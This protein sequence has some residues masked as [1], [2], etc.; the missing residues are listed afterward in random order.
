MMVG[1]VL[2]ATELLSVFNHCAQGLSMRGWGLGHMNTAQLFNMG[3]NIHNE[4]E[5][6]RERMLRCQASTSWRA[7]A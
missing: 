2:R 4:T 6:T 7:W 5:L 3:A 1:R